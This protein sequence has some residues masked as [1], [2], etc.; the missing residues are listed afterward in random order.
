MTI[1]LTGRAPD[2]LDSAQGQG[3][4]QALAQLLLNSLFAGQSL[5][6]F[7]IEPDGSVRLGVP[8][9]QSIYATSTLAATQNPT[10]NRL[11]IGLEWSLFP[12]VVASGS[13][14]DR[15]SNAELYWEIRF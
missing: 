14:G 12:K 2:D 8:I 10:E 11:S 9:S 6:S 1:L 15:R 13:V 4:A 3:T 7:S 5:G